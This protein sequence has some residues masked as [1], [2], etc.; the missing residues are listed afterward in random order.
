MY[1]LIKIPQQINPHTISLQKSK[2]KEI[3]RCDISP[4]HKYFEQ[5]YDFFNKKQEKRNVQT[6]KVSYMWFRLRYIDSQGELSSDRYSKPRNSISQVVCDFSS[7]PEMKS[8]LK[9]KK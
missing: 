2:S 1:R 4:A 3:K 8:S 6:I 5:S 7:K 9:P